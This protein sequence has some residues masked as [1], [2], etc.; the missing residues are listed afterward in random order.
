MS[1]RSRP[2][3][4]SCGR[5][6]TARRSPCPTRTRATNASASS[7]PGTSCCSSWCPAIA[8]CVWQHRAHANLW[9]FARSGLRFTPG[10]AV[11]WWFVPIA[12][13]WK[14]FEAV[15]EL[16]KASDPGSDPLSW[17]SVAHVA[18]ARLVVVLLARQRRHQRRGLCPAWHRPRRHDQ[19]R[20]DR[21][22]GARPPGRGR[23]ARDR[24]RPPGGGSSDG[25]RADG[26][27]HARATADAAACAPDAA[28]AH[29]A[30]LPPCRWRSTSTTSR[31]S[32]AS[33]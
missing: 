11:G 31:S 8:W 20:H 32:R 2:R 14:P 19:G 28:D 3:R 18:H 27:G 7:R 22:G 24:D 6:V 1:G 16:W 5:C 12:S 26:R 17:R 10:W 29:A 13:L 15:R 9:A 4:R 23:R 33:T 21:D 25:A 30:R